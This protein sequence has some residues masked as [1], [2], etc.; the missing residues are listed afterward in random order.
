MEYEGRQTGG[1][2]YGRGQ[3][4]LAR[5]LLPFWHSFL[6]RFAGSCPPSSLAQPSNLGLGHIPCLRSCLRLPKPVSD[7]LVLRIAWCSPRI[8]VSGLSPSCRSQRLEVWGGERVPPTV[9]SNKVARLIGQSCH[10]LIYLSEFLSI[11]I[12]IFVFYPSIHLSEPSIST[13]CL[14]ARSCSGFHY[15]SRSFHLFLDLSRPLILS[16][17]LHLASMDVTKTRSSRN[18]LSGL[19]L[20]CLREGVSHVRGFARHARTA[21]T[22]TLGIPGPVATR[23]P[24]ARPEVHII[25]DPQ[26]LPSKKCPYCRPGTRS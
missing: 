9:W 3:G 4:G 11:G 12:S 7:Q 10:F 24:A 23:P 18:L 5:W 2:A 17:L 15:R 14:L 26:W 19:C 22:L 8:L 20:I 21:H 25:A 13:R 6:N 16:F 1:A